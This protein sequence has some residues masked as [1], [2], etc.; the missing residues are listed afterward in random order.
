MHMDK[1]PMIK[2]WD[3]QNNLLTRR[4]LAVKAFILLKITTMGRDAD[5][6]N[7]SAKHSFW[8]HNEVS[9]EPLFVDIWR[10]A[11]SKRDLLRGKKQ[12]IKPCRVYALPQEMSNICLVRTCKTYKLRLLEIKRQNTSLLAIGRHIKRYNRKPWRIGSNSTWTRQE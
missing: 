5:I 6:R 1:D 10:I 4:E 11:P 9:D 12:A 7:M 2:F 8:R 3:K